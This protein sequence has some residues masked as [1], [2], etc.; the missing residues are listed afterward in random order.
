MEHITM[1]LW[2][3]AVRDALPIFI[4]ATVLLPAI[5][6]FFMH[7]KELPLLGLIMALVSATSIVPLLSL[8]F[9]SNTQRE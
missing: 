4:L 7:N 8:L 3:L 5:A 2:K 6:F 1:D 9:I